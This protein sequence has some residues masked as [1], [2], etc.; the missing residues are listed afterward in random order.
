[1]IAM[2]PFLIHASSKSVND[3]PRRVL[4]ILYAPSLELA[5]DIRL[6]VA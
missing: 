2:R 3:H 4:H 6:A 5:P 1:V